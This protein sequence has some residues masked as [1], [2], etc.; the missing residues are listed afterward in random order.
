MQGD[1][2]LWFNL[3]VIIVFLVNSGTKKM[4]HHKA[5]QHECRSGRRI[6]SWCKKGKE[7]IFK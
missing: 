2:L 6:K 5:A 4:L 3:W 1:M 7:G